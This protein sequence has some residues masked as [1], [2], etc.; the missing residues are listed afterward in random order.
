MTE[1]PYRIT[2]R[3]RL[4]GYSGESTF[5]EPVR[6]RHNGQRRRIDDYAKD[7][8]VLLGRE[9]RR[10]LMSMGRWLYSN[11]S[12]VRGA[13]NEMASL[14]TSSF[15]PQFDGTDNAWGDLAEDWLYNHDRV[16]DVRGRPYDMAS[17][18][19]LL[20]LSVLR[21]GDVFVLLTEAENG[22]PMFQ[23]VPAHRVGSRLSA[24]ET[25]KGGPFAGLS[26]V[27]GVVMNDYGRAVAYQVLGTDPEDDRIIDNASLVAVYCPDYVDQ[28][29]GISALATAVIDFQDIHESRRLE[30]VAQKLLAALTL[31]ES[32]ETGMADSAAALLGSVTSST[33]LDEVTHSQEYY[34]G[35]VRY[36]R[37]GTGSKIEPIVGD[38]P[39]TNQQ[40]FADSIIRQALHGIG[41]SYD[42][43]LDPTK[44]GG[45]NSR[46]VIEKINARL[47]EL[48]QKILAPVRR[49]MDGYRIAKAI[50]LGLLPPSDEWMQWAY[51]GPAKITADAR[52]SSDV[53]K[54]EFQMGFTTMD[55]V[56][57]E[58]GEWWQDVVRQRAREAAYITEQ[59]AANGVPVQMVQML[60]PNGNMA[61]PD[62][63]EETDSTDDAEE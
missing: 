47:E 50:K 27:D 21:D 43:S 52:H 39:T 60:T 25:V 34:G 17:L 54:Q 58:R 63:D 19:R 4:Y 1:K 5:L 46:L 45:A 28:L 48:R 57:A 56:C 6:T 61:E 55:R 31:V 33:T 24:N 15:I 13:V 49:V 14:A 3:R 11:S 2:D 9:N 53:A 16:C 42:F 62:A 59:A 18:N 12:I 26:I 30:L 7:A 38:R 40:S 23:I 44:A 29:R 32:N 35:E 37:A 41:W 51:Q 10:T 20:I 36:F 22:W 8:P